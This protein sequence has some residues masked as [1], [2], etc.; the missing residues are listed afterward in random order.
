MYGI[1]SKKNRKKT[2]KNAFTELTP[3]TTKLK[4]N[5]IT[6]WLTSRTDQNRNPGS[7]SSTAAVMPQ[8]RDGAPNTAVPQIR[9]TPSHRQGKP[10]QPQPSTKPTSVDWRR[11]PVQVRLLRP[12]LD[13]WSLER[14]QRRGRPRSRELYHSSR[15]TSRRTLARRHLHGRLSTAMGHE[16]RLGSLRAPILG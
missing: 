9:A 11:E 12:T 7:K 3:P 14:R 5:P 4:S 15:T 1:A 10:P 6:T 2:N 13:R 8:T 16:G